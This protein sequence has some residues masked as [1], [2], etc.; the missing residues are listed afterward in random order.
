MSQV[1]N[2]WLRPLTARS[3]IASTL[4]GLPQPRLP[5]AALVASGEKFGVAPGTTRVA[6][7]RMVDTGELVG[8]ADGAYE[9]AGP[10]L[11]R[12][13]RQEQGRH[14]QTRTWTGDWRI[15]VVT[16]GARS[17]AE[18]ASLRR[19]MATQRFAELRE[20]VWMR[21]DNLDVALDPTCIWVVGTTDEQPQVET[22]FGLDDWA[23]TA[24]RLLDALSDTVGSLRKRDADALGETFVIAAATTRHLTVDPLLPP[25]LLPRAWPGDELRKAYDQYQDHFSATGRHWYRSTLD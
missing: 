15:G 16:G 4:L 19:T 8:A 1:R 10:L 5:A 14:P 2:S 18:R 7:S 17:A 13:A 22:L 24:H 21:P 11:A 3:V 25:E 9:L 23:A 12:H 6:L 20:G